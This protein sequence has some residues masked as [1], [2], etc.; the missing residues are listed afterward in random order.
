MDMAATHPVLGVGYENWGPY[1]EAHYFSPTDSLAAFHPNGRPVIEVA[2]NS[3]V[4]VAS[5]LGYVGLILFVCLLC[6]VFLVDTRARR[7]LRPLGERGR[8]LFYMSY[9]VDAGVI[10]FAVAGFFMSVAFYPFV[11]FQLGA[12]GALHAA[13]VNLAK[14]CSAIGPSQAGLGS[15]RAYIGHSAERTSNRPVRHR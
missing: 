7:I 2:H 13:A 11:W 8:F 1:Y 9:G 6:S 15:S 12:A 3:F 5:Q 14:S 10:A 4:E